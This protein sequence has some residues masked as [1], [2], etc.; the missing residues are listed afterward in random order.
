MFQKHLTQNLHNI[1]YETNYQYKQF[2]IAIMRERVRG[3]FSYNV[4]VQKGK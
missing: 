1:Q 3:Y 2:Y 4:G